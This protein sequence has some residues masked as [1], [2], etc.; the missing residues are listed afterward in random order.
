LLLL[1]QNKINEALFGFKA[2]KSESI[3]YKLAE[4]TYKKVISLNFAMAKNKN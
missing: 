3:F 2:K 1:Q 4:P